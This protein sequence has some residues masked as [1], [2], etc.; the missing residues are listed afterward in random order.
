ME[1]HDFAIGRDLSWACNWAMSAS[2]SHAFIRLMESGRFK[3]P[4]A[5]MAPGSIKR[6]ASNSSSKTAANSHRLHPPRVELGDQGTIAGLA[7]DEAWGDTITG[8]GGF[9]ACAWCDH[10]DYLVLLHQVV[11]HS[12]DVSSREALF[13]ILDDIA[14]EALDGDRC[15]VFT[16]QRQL[17]AVATTSAACARVLARPPLPAPCCARSAAR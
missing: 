4:V 15:A 16:H 10:N 9:A 7:D 2:Q 5:P 1:F 14:A 13:D 8:S 12:Q 17:G 3:M 6:S 11:K